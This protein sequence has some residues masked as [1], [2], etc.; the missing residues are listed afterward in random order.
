MNKTQNFIE[1][2]F[3]IHCDKYDYCKTSYIN[4]TTNVTIICK[5]HGEFQLTPNKHISS[6]RGCQLCSKNNQ[7]NE[8]RDTIEEFINKSKNIHGNRYDYSNTEY[9]NST[10]KVNII[11]KEHGEFL[12]SPSVHKMGMGCQ[13]CGNNYRPDTKEFIENAIKIHGNIYDYSKVKYINNTTPITIICKIH[14]EFEQTPDCHLRG[15]N[16]MKCRNEYIRKIKRKTTNDFIHDSNQIHGDKYE[17][18]K[19]DYIDSDTKVIII[20]KEHGSFEQRPCNHLKGNGCIK[21][22]NNYTLIKSEFIEKASLIHGNKYDYSNVEYI[23]NKDSIIINCNIHGNFSQILSIHLKGHGCSKCA[24]QRISETQFINNDFIKKASLIHGNKYDYS[25]VYYKGSNIKL[26]I[27]CK[28]HGDFYKTPDNHIHKKHPQGCPKCQKIKQYSHSQIK[29]LNII[30]LIYNIHI[31]HAENGNEYCI[32]DT[33][34]KADGFCK[35]TNTIYEFHGDY[36]HGNPYIYRKDEINDVSKKTF[37]E[38]YQN[39]LNKEKII[40]NMGYNLVVMWE[41][42]WNKINK[43]IKI[44]QRKYHNYINLK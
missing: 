29:W 44:L 34:Y 11:C 30:Q 5:E 8:K 18:S 16:C 22:S 20:C 14:G 9:I 15:Y 17:Y 41:Y 32:P 1:K 27:I 33:K 7:Y 13:K 6:K 24:R 35:E 37:G 25:N 38:L 26:K 12:Q 10:T 4:A 19:V 21:C 39:T 31:Q 40:K 23:N 28:E 42:D 3:K 43:S 36:W 2:A